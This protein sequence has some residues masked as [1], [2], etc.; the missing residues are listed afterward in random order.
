MSSRKDDFTCDIVESLGVLSTSKAG[1]TRELN[2][3]SWNG[4]DPKFD[5]RDWD[6]EHEKCSK[7]IALSEEEARLIVE[8]LNAYFEENE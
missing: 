5:I 1:W 8:K 6:P 2:R 7:G 4:G 3:I